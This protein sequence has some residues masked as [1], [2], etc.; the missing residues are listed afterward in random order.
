MMMSSFPTSNSNAY[1]ITYGILILV[2]KENGKAD[3]FPF[4]IVHL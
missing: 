1:Y 2:T 3:V 4:V